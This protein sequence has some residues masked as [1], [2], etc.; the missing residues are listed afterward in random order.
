MNANWF[1]DRIGPFF[2]GLGPLWSDEF[3]SHFRS[4]DRHFLWP[5]QIEK[6]DDGLVV[7]MRLDRDGDGDFDLVQTSTKS[8]LDTGGKQVVVDLRD[9][10][11][12]LLRKTIATS[13]E[14]G[15][16]RVVS[17][18]LNGDGQIDREVNSVLAEDG[19]MTR[20]LSLFSET[21]ELES[22]ER[23]SLSQFGRTITH[24]WDRD[25]DG[26]FE[27]QTVHHVIRN[28]DGDLFGAMAGFG[29]VWR[30][31]PGSELWNFEDSLMSGGWNAFNALGG[32]DPDRLFPRPHDASPSLPTTEGD[33]RGQE[34]GIA[35][36]L[37]AMDPDQFFFVEA[38]VNGD[39]SD[40]AH[41]WAHFS[42][43]GSSY[44]ESHPGPTGGHNF[45]SETILDAFGHSSPYNEAAPIILS[46]DDFLFV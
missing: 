40:T 32:P 29:S 43:P 19:T 2:S 7:T 28:H 33:H 12:T 27:D 42:P 6:S 21:G 13:S 37:G 35:D 41:D 8:S 15:H 20:T 3:L 17:V 9:G 14:D 34:L 26:Q 23:V 36:L 38:P 24:E 10:S 18:D 31:N 4:D 39:P 46:P 45:G 5:F 30:G 1:F 25:G 16:S 22:Q 44:R 11:G